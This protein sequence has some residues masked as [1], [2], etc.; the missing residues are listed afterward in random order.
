M[1]F[2]Q[3]D[4]GIVAA[5]FSRGIIAA[6]QRKIKGRNGGIEGQLSI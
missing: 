1:D 3:V 6:A 4:P 2:L 5:G